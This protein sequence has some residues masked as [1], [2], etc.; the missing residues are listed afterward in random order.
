M[1][2]FIPFF[3]VLQ[4]LSHVHIKGDVIKKGKG[5]RIGIDGKPLEGEPEL[6]YGAKKAIKKLLEIIIKELTR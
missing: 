2:I 5:I 1:K 6:P 4:N 3:F